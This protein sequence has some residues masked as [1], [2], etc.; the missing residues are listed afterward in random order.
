MKPEIV[1]ELEVLSQSLG[2]KPSSTDK[3]CDFIRDLIWAGKLK[4]GDRIVE[5]RYARELRIGQPTVREALKTLE[6]EGLVVRHPNRGC[7]VVE[8]SFKQVN[9]IFLLRVEWEALAVGLSMDD[10][11]EWKTKRLMEAVQR[12]KDAALQNDVM[13]YYHRDFEFHK[14]LWQ[15]SDNPFLEKALSQVTFLLFSFQMIELIQHPGYDFVANAESHERIAR[16]VISGDKEL[17]N[18]L[19]RATLESFRKDYEEYFAS[20]EGATGLTTGS[21]S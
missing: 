10:W 5:T 18:K 14:T 16:A 17:A 7:S 6:L 13:E 3:V 20:R 8:L 1:A 9:Q 12:M 11:A 4:P 19:V 2:Q 15:L 21:R